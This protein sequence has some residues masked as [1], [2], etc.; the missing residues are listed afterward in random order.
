MFRNIIWRP[1][2]KEYLSSNI[3]FFTTAEVQSSSSFLVINV[4]LPLKLKYELFF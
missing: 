3:V 2:Y 4:G 1:Y